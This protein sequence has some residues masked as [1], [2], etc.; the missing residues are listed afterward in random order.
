M[1]EPRKPKRK[2]PEATLQTKVMH[3]LRHEQTEY[4]CA[5][6]N[7]P[8][9]ADAGMPDAFCISPTGKYVGLELKNPKGGVQS[10][11]QKYWQKEIEKRGGEYHL[12]RSMEELKDLLKIR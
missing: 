8:H 9:S 3:Y 11:K 12:V 10:S 2:K 6:T 1:F 7:M 4:K 5:L